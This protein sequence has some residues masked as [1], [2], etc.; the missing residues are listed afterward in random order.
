MSE[1]TTDQELVKQVQSGNKNAFNLLVV[2]HQNK[3]MNIVSRYV[4]NSGD[5]ADVT[6]EA[7]IKAYRALPNFRGESAFYTWLYRIAVNSAKN[8]L[9]SQSRKPPASDVGAQEANFYDGS[10]ALKENASP[11]K[12]LLSEELQTKLFAAIESLPDDLRAAITLREIEGLSYE[13]IAAVM[14]CP[15]GTVRSRIFRAREAIDKVILP[16]IEN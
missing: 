1:Q 16:L 9:T 2:R 3:V 5:V 4:K 8:Y 13:E 12:T 14:E 6:Q 15:V 7:F 10:D 11:E